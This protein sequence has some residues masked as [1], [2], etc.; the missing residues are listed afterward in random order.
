MVYLMLNLI[1]NIEK[2]IIKCVFDII[3]YHKSNQY[4]N[5]LLFL[6]YNMYKK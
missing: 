2:A 3:F 4:T 1:K 5:K 6:V